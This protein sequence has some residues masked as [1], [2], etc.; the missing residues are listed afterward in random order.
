M[1]LAGH[2]GSNAHK[3]ELQVTSADRVGDLVGSMSWRWPAVSHLPS[4]LLRA[5]Q[6][7]R[8]ASSCF[9]ALAK[10]RAVGILLV[11]VPRTARYGAA[12]YDPVELLGDV[13]PAPDAD[14]RPEFL[15]IGG[16]THLLSALGLRDDLSHDDRLTVAN[17]CVRG[18]IERAREEGL[19]AVATHVRDEDTRLFLPAFQAPLVKQIDARCTLALPDGGWMG[20]LDSLTG[21]A[22]QTVR[23]EMDAL[24]G[25]GLL[26]E[27]QQVDAVLEAA[28]PLVVNV[29]A[30]HGTPEHPRLAAARM[31]AWA[32]A[33]ESTSIAFAIRERGA[34]ISAVSVCAHQGDTLE[35]YE[36][37]LPVRHEL[38]RLQYAEV[39]FYAPIRYAIEHGIPKLDFGLGPVNTKRLR[40][41]SAQPVWTVVDRSG[42]R[43]C[44]R[45]RE[46]P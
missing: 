12:A 16:T 6:D 13:G 34:R 37:G 43:D 25:L 31:K 20:Y 17:A 29:K 27:R 14:A 24:R 26:A 18:A 11:Q 46:G 32:S 1:N 21:S 2:R 10:G 33:A 28:A 44:R 7:R 39:L 45:G 23:K 38:R 30:R 15:H 35:V 36:V 19:V 40:G 42:L 22:R 4:A 8:W 9:V 3:L 5:S 41:A